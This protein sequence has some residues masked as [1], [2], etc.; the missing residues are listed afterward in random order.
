MGGW[1][2]QGGWGNSLYRI[3]HQTQIKDRK[4]ALVIY[5]LFVLP[6]VIVCT[7]CFGLRFWL[8]VIAQQ[9]LAMLSWF[10]RVFSTLPILRLRWLPDPWPIDFLHQLT[11]QQF[12]QRHQLSQISSRLVCFAFCYSTIS[13]RMF[14]TSAVWTN[15]RAQWPLAYLISWLIDLFFSYVT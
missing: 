3:I 14:S 12:L 6:E 9:C 8:S 4:A 10:Y 5:I 11:K 1:Y 2:V 7:K 13:L 15:F